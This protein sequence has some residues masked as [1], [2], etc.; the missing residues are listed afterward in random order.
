M[1]MSHIQSP[2]DIQ[3]EL[4]QHFY[5]NVLDMLNNNYSYDGNFINLKLLSILLNFWLSKLDIWQ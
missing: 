1:M 2:V 5:Q 4:T 3:S